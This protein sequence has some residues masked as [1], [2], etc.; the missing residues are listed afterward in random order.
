MM[1]KYWLTEDIMWCGQKI[2]HKGQEVYDMGVD[3][4]TVVGRYVPDDE[5]I[6]CTNPETHSCQTYVLKRLLVENPS[7]IP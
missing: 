1:K 2:L 6:I 5:T 4:D 7:Q 3:T